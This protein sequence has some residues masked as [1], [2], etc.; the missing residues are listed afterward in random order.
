MASGMCPTG[1]RSTLASI[2]AALELHCSWPSR[3]HVLSALIYFHRTIILSTANAVNFHSSF[4]ASHNSAERGALAAD[5]DSQIV[6]GHLM[7][8]RQNH[9]ASLQTAIELTRMRAATR[10][11]RSPDA[12]CP[13]RP[14]HRHQGAAGL[15]ESMTQ[16]R[17]GRSCSLQCR[18][19]HVHRTI[20]AHHCRPRIG[21][22]SL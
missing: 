10:N 20:R 14:R 16:H 3:R 11:G 6:E 5:S 17:K 4:S 8:L 19:S 18:I 12:T 7:R 22:R 1:F 13:G 2:F 21:T 9:T 15:A